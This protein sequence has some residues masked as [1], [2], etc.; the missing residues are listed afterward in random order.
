MY[1]V[2]PQ[3][4]PHITSPQVPVASKL[5]IRVINNV[6]KR[7]EVKPKFHESFSQT[8]EGYPEC[9]PYTQKVGS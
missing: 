1:R 8:E 7:L 9:F 4:P 5:T 6:K 2:T 3:S